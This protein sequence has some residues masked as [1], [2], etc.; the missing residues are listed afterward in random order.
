MAEKLN[1]VLD[2]IFFL[3]FFCAA[4]EAAPDDCRACPVGLQSRTRERGAYS[5]AS[6]RSSIVRRAPEEAEDS[7]AYAGA[8]SPCIASGR[9]A[10]CCS[11]RWRD[12]ATNDG[13]LQ[14]AAVHV[15]RVRHKWSATT[16]TACPRLTGVA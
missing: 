2:V 1:R 7:V 6:E 3:V 12:R 11:G 15:R 4:A 16:T 5:A 10:A 14:A 8:P 9:G 13:R